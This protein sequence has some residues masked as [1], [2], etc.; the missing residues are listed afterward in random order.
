[1][2]LK[3][4]ALSEIAAIDHGFCNR[5]GGMSG[6]VFESL[7]VG[8]GRG[9]D[10]E[11][12]I[13]NREIISNRFGITPSQFVTLNQVHSDIVR[14]VNSDNIEEYKFSD[15]E[16]MNRMEGDAI[17][18]NV[19][20]T[21]IGIH[22]ADCA[23]ILLCDEKAGFVSAIHSGWRGTVGRI[24]ENTVA[25]LIGLG[26]KNLVV[27]IGPCIQKPSF[28]VNDEIINNV[29]RKYISTIENKKFFDMP[30]MIY[31]KFAANNE[32]KVITRIGV[33]TVSDENF[34]SYRRQNGHC[35]VQFSGILLRERSL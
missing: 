30:Q 3:S 12:V 4:D 6:G 7:N 20:E 8:F 19:A 15:P 32:V 28:E 33:D 10:S 5:R 21:L 24:I 35:G 26:C 34:F 18:T 9:D 16:N 13:K 27:A 14:F 31:D 17:I 22:T 1:M 29:D 25:M 11:K 23:P 2:I